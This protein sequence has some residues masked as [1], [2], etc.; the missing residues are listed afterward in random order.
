MC[1]AR[2]AAGA[3]EGHQGEE[4]GRQG[5]AEAGTLGINL[6]SQGQQWVGLTLLCEA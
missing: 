6:V 1:G 3:A 5:E 4:Q 2:E